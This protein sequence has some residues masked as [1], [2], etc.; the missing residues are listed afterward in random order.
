VE[1][2]LLK[3]KKKIAEHSLRLAKSFSFSNAYRISPC[4]SWLLAEISARN[5]KNTSN[6]AAKIVGKD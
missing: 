2:L 3:V 5:I 1:Q 6:W 4:F